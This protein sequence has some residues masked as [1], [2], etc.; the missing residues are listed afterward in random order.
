MADF[1]EDPNDRASLW[2]KIENDPSA[3]VKVN[4]LDQ[5][6]TGTLLDRDSF[7]RADFYEVDFN[8]YASGRSRLPK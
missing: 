5:M 1:E 3:L 7:H 6:D 8:D 4:L 2:K